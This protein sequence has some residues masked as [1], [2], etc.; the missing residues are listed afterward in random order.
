MGNP[1]ED[2]RERLS[3][4]AIQ[5]ESLERME[6]RLRRI[7]NKLD[8]AEGLI[9]LVNE[10]E[11]QKSLCAASLEQLLKI[12]SSFPIGGRKYEVLS[13]K[14]IDDMPWWK[15]GEQ[16]YLSESACR[17]LEQQAIDEL[18]QLNNIKK[19]P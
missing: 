18:I 2:M 10:I 17:K 14:Y 11:T 15:V 1:R 12:I 5:C 6:T 9:K 7:L 19:S 4:Y 16:M 8:S 13:L 3:E